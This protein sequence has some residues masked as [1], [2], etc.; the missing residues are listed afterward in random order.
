VEFVPVLEDLDLLLV[1]LALM[2]LVGE[3]R[4]DL[5]LVRENH[6][7]GK[8]HGHLSLSA[9][10]RAEHTGLTAERKR[11]GTP[12]ENSDSGGGR[13]PVAEKTGNFSGLRLSEARPYVRGER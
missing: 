6:S 9:G 11:P 1:A 2:L 10:A 4:K 8:R 7:L 12:Y 5:V 3:R 13:C